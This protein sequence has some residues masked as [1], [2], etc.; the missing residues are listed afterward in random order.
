[1][2]T[3]NE[4]IIQQQFIIRD[5]QFGDSPMKKKKKRKLFL[6]LKDD[7]LYSKQKTTHFPIPKKIKSTF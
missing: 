7:K 6:R 4:L 5:L 3:E 2:I 1:M